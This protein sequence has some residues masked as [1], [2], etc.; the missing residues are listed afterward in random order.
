MGKN[1]ALSCLEDFLQ[2]WV[3]ACPATGQSLGKFINNAGV[4]SEPQID[5][6]V[7]RTSMHIIDRRDFLVPLKMKEKERK[8]E[9]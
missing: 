4:H 7:A 1:T 5:L 2:T 6:C 8:E 9:K 3:F